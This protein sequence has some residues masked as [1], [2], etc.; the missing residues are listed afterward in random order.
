MND[1]NISKLT[2]V[3]KYGN[4]ASQK[5]K[6]KDGANVFKCIATFSDGSKA[7][8]NPYWTCPILLRNVVAGNIDAWGV[9]GR[10]RKASVTINASSN[11][12]R[13][14]ELACWVSPPENNLNLPSASIGFDYS[15]IA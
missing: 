1:F 11:H 2:I 4:P 10:D 8:F 12:E 9:L 5:Y 7:E 15:N 6:L 14:T 3:D 13:Y